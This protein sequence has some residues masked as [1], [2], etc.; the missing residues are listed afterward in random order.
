MRIPLSKAR[1]QSSA[2]VTMIELVIVILIIGILAVIAVP[3]WPTSV[4]LEFEARR[5]LSDIRYTQGLSMATGERYRWVKV[6][7]NSYQITNEAGT[8]IIMP[9]GATQIVLVDQAVFG[10]L[11]NLPNSLLAFDSRGVP[12]TDASIPGTALAATATI[13][14]TA[15]GRTRTVSI[16][17]ETG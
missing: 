2:G 16:T 1:I 14:I 6:A 11:S 15:S 8:P 3:K 7:A 17:P 4:N 9:S 12:Y 13:S 5:L 10:T